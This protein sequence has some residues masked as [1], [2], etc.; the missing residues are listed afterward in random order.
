MKTKLKS[1]LLSGFMVLAMGIGW[2]P[3]QALAVEIGPTIEWQQ[4]AGDEKIKL[5]GIL[6]TS[7]H[8]FTVGGL[9]G[10]KEAYLSRWDEQGKLEW[11]SNIQLENPDYPILTRPATISHVT[12]TKDGGYLLRGVFP[13]IHPRYDEPFIA[14]IDQNGE[15][16]WRKIIN[17]SGGYVTVA[18]VVEFP[19]GSIVYTS[20]PGI[21][22]RQDIPA[23]IGKIDASGQT[24]WV[25]S[26]NVYSG[27]KEYFSVVNADITADG[28][29]IV[30]AYWNSG[31]EFKLWKLSQSGELLWSK[32]MQQSGRVNSVS[33]GYL[34]TSIPTYGTTETQIFKLDEDGNA[35]GSVHYDT[36]EINQISENEDGYLLAAD[37]GLFQISVS[38][39]LLW[40]KEIGQ[41]EDVIQIN[42]QEIFALAGNKLVKLSNGGSENPGDP[43][44]PVDPNSSLRFDSEEYSISR[45]DTFDTIVSWY[46]QDG[47]IVNVSSYCT[48]SSSRPDILGIDIEGNI[49][50]ISRGTSVITA[51][52]GDQTAS[53]KVDVY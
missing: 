44:D 21:V 18:S 37:R 31:G 41:V 23:K 24:E 47:K 9:S 25:H 20:T 42:D 10:A 5:T 28:E 50:G 7:D 53:A 27:S 15:L 32:P 48:F 49:T 29:I 13:D 51:V 40:S 22:G 38:G 16:L 34:F 19:D 30:S 11:N 35:L 43:T 2:V 52:Y 46:D 33:D 36:G 3:G 4:E 1:R 8:Q 14:K 26:V 39:S 6:Q 12:P 45:G 17:T